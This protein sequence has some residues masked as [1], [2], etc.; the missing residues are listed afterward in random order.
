MRFLHM[1]INNYNKNSASCFAYA[2]AMRSAY[3][4]HSGS[5][6]ISTMQPH[7]RLRPCP[8]PPCTCGMDRFLII[9]YSLSTII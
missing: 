5:R 4:A 8:V 2:A 3:K 7:F 9:V 6:D 1:N